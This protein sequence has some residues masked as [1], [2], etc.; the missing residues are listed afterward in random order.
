MAVSEYVQAAL[1]ADL[2][3]LK[4]QNKGG[5]HPRLEHRKQG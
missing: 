5:V 4:P 3:V 2:S 1:V